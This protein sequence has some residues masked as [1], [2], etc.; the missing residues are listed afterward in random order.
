M[1]KVNIFWRLKPA[2]VFLILVLLTGLLV[3][4]GPT[5]ATSEAPTAAPAVE[6]TSTR[7]LPTA[8]RPADTPEPTVPP[9][10]PTATMETAAVD[11]CLDCH[12]DKDRLIDTADP[13]QEVISENKGEG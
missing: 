9:V 2:G 11:G 7:V 8:T 12:S 13:E 3:G 1:Q 5:A 6:A 10:E 4:C